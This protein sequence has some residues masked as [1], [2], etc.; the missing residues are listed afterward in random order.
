VHNDFV[1][2]IEGRH[3]AVAEVFDDYQKLTGRAPTSWRDHALAHRGEY[4]ATVG[5]AA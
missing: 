2:R 1:R 5:G 3:P 4:V